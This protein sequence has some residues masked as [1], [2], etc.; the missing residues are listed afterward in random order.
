MFTEQLTSFS[1]IVLQILPKLVCQEHIES[2]QPQVNT[3]LRFSHNAEFTDMQINERYS[4]VTINK[5]SCPLKERLMISR[6]TSEI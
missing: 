1:H 4:K 2:I 5:K 3:S 6:E